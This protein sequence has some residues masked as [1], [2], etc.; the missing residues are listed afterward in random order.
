MSTLKSIH[1]TT[2]NTVVLKGKIN[3][4]SVGYVIKEILKK[5]PEYMYIDSSGGSIMAGSYLLET[6]RNVKIKCIIG[7]AYSMAF[8]ILQACD[9]RYILPTSTAM[10]HQA[11]LRI[12][13]ELLQVKEYI[14]M[15]ET[16]E[17]YMNDMQSVRIGMTKDAFV[18]KVKTEWWLYGVNIIKHGIADDVISI[19]CSKELVNK[20]ITIREVDFIFEITR[21][22]SACPLIPD[23]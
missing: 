10:Q 18:D 15:V 3:D 7:K 23:T 16:M 1:L 4:E 2:N 12:D 11:S 17:D 6:L 9:K 22:Y 19:T 13:G 5:E 20:K 8:V 21:K 14:A